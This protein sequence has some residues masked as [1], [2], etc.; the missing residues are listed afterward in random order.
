MFTPNRSGGIP[1]GRPDPEKRNPAA[2]AS[3]I[4]GVEFDLGALML[5]GTVSVT[6]NL[7]PADSTVRYAM[8]DEGAAMR[9][10]SR[11]GFA[12]IGQA[13]ADAVTLADFLGAEA[14]R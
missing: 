9:L 10:L 1:R 5:G 7:D 8:S 4:S 3:L 2:L 14:R 6:I 12:E 13:E 11:G